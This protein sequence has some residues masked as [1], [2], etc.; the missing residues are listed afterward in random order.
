[1]ESLDQQF[2][3]IVTI[4]FVASVKNWHENM[5]EVPFGY[6]FFRQTISAN[7]EFGVILDATND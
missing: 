1:M 5:T 6:T 3:Y 7:L 4:A 2:I